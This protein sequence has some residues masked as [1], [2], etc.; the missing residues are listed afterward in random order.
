M[1]ILAILRSLLCQGI[2]LGGLLLLL[3]QRLRLEL[4][5]AIEAS[6]HGTLLDIMH[7]KM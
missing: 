1:Q 7:R 6:V 5:C 4:G 2:A 3:S